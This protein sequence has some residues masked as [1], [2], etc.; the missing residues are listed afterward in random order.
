MA[1]LTVY[2]DRGARSSLAKTTLAELGINHTVVDCENDA[3]GIEFLESKGRDR[4][5]YPL[6]Q[7]YVGDKLA[8]E[9]GF[10]DF[11]GL[12]AAQINSKIEELNAS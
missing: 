11:N 5:H 1:N 3:S 9:N 7:F 6:P 12:T 2:T 8:W 4:S 10:K